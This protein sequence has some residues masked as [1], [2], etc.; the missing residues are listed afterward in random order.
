[1]TQDVLNAI[2][3]FITNENTAI[4]EIAKEAFEKW[5]KAQSNGYI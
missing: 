1:M 5:E 4:A 3:P 2:T